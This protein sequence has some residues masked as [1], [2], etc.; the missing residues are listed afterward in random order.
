MAS[1]TSM[2][3]GRFKSKARRSTGKNMAKRGRKSKSRKG[4]SSGGTSGVFSG[5]ILGFKIPLV[6]DALRNKTV[7]KAIAGA[8]IVSIALTIAGLVNNPT[9]NR[10]LGNKFVRLG[11]AGAAGDVTGIAAE[12]VKEGGIGQIRGAAAGAGNGGQASL[13]S[14]PGGGVA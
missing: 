14:V 4:R 13:M 9:V 3:T 2:A 1:L 6:G 5:K 7:Q 8:G 12:F 10:A 11:L